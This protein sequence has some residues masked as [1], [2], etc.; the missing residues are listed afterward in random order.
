MSTIIVSS[1]AEVATPRGAA[2]AASLASSIL[3]W[4]SSTASAVQHSREV[5][6]RV[7]EASQVRRL[8]QQVMRDDPRFAA[9]LFA[10]A[11]RHE[12]C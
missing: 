6:T 3:N 5:A 8:A 4:F 11:D 10:A 9:D 7:R 1:P 12:R 2:W